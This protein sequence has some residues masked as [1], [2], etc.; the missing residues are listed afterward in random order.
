MVAFI[1]IFGHLGTAFLATFS[2]AS[3]VIRKPIGPVLSDPVTRQLFADAL[4]E[5]VAV[6]QAEGVVLGRDYQAKQMAFCDSI[7]AETKPSMLMDLERGHP[8]EL[9]WLSGAVAELGD[10]TGVRTPIHHFLCAAL[11]LYASGPN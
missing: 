4:S 10:E 8:L 6:A 9:E 3:T 2:G 11:K 5:A 7:P 1:P